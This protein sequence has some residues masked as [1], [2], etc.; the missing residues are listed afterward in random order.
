MSV[1]TKSWL[2]NVGN[3]NYYL[4]MMGLSLLFITQST[5]IK[6]NRTLIPYSR[7]LQ[8]HYSLGVDGLSISKMINNIVETGEGSGASRHMCNI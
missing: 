2:T 1:N 8:L 4:Y 3:N 5:V 6:Y 7:C